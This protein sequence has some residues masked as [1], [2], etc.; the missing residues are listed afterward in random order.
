MMM[1]EEAFR[2]E[3]KEL[4]VV[5]AK[6]AIMFRI[7]AEHAEDVNEALRYKS[8]SDKARQQAREW[9][10]AAHGEQVPQVIFTVDENDTDPNSGQ[11]G[12]E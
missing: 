3:A 11:G 9:L 6:S 5:F 7:L 12:V 2:K 10:A 8:L 4:S 1:S